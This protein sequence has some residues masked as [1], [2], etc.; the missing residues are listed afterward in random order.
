MIVVTPYTLDCNEVIGLNI[1][2]KAPTMLAA[3]SELNQPVIVATKHFALCG[4]ADERFLITEEKDDDRTS[5][6]LI[7]SG[8]CYQGRMQYQLDLV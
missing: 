1:A 6:D 7:K 5:P 8:D 2:V 4:S 3:A